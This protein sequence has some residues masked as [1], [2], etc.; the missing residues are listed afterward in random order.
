MTEFDKKI[1]QLVSEGKL[2]EAAA[3]MNEN[4][5][6]YWRDVYPTFSDEE[7][8]NTWIGEINVSMRRHGENGYDPMETFDRKSYES[9]LSYEPRFE[10]LWPKILPRIN[11]NPNKVMELLGLK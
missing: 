3:L 6:T 9:W 1:E 8:I 11:A 5:R 10:E 2:K 7:K 4:A